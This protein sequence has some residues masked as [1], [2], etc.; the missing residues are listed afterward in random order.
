[1]AKKKPNFKMRTVK[2]P[3]LADD[4]NRYRRHSEQSARLEKSSPGFSKLSLSE[5]A[6]RLDKL[7]TER[8]ERRSKEAGGFRNFLKKTIEDNPAYFRSAAKRL[9]KGQPA[10][11]QSSM[12][13]FGIRLDA[14]YADK[15]PKNQRSSK[16][17]LVAARKKEA[18]RINK[19]LDEAETKKAMRKAAEAKTRKK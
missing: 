1:M 15:T 14:R 10:Q 6:K 16:K 18:A 11:S 12:T 7:E 8:M 17:A 3:L 2:E 5:Q 9:A 4:D 19:I 13:D